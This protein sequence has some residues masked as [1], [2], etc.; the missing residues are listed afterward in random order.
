MG[1]EGQRKLDIQQVSL[2]E[3]EERW[4]VRKSKKVKNIYKEQEN[5]VILERKERRKGNEREKNE[6]KS[7][8]EQRLKLKQPA[9]KP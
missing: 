1:Q 7:N 6:N 4:Q 3:A 8:S 5:L 2:W 9:K